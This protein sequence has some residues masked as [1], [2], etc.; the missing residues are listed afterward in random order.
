MIDVG[1]FVFYAIYRVSTDSIIRKPGNDFE[2][3]EEAEEWLKD[4]MDYF[5]DDKKVRIVK[6]QNIIFV[7]HLKELEV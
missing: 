2:S 6:V 4:N 3:I 5:K 7:D 1:N